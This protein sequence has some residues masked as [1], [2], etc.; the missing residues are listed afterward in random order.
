MYV[1][2]TPGDYYNQDEA[3]SHLV[4][5]HNNALDYRLFEEFATRVSH[6]GV[7]VESANVV[8]A[9]TLIQTLG[10]RVRHRVS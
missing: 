8:H 2:M 10:F 3:S 9:L 7:F 5:F 6:E 1:E 4:L